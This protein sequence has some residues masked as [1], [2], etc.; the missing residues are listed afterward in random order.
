MVMRHKSDF[1]GCRNDTYFRRLDLCCVDFQLNLAKSKVK[2]IVVA[3]PHFCEAQK[4]SPMTTTT[5][6]TTTMTTTATMLVVQVVIEVV[7]I[8][9]IWK[10][11]STL[12][13]VTK[14]ELH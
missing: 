14:P 8:I 4:T 7:M 12:S 5:T 11:K 2:L 6:T 1:V 10:C 9:V 3:G 13:R